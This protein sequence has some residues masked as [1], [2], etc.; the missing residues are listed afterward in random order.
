MR[1]PFLIGCLI[2]VA[3]ASAAP[4]T[5]VTG[6]WRAVLLIPD[7]GTQSISLELDAR[8]ETV[9]GSVEGLA[10]REGRLD[11]STLTLTLSAPNNQEVSLTG[12]VSGDEIVFKSTGLPPGPIQ[13]VARRNAPAVNGSV[14]DP[15]VVQQ[16][17]KQFNVPGVSI[18]VINDFKIVATYAYGVANVETRAPLTT[19]TMFQAASISKPVAAMVS[20]KAVQNGRFSLDQDVNTILKSWKLPDGPFTKERRVTPRSLMSHTSGTG[21][22]FGFPGYPPRAMLPSIPHMLD[23]VQPPSNLRAVRLERA[24]LTGFKYSGGAVMIQQ[25]AL[26]DAVGKPFEEV[27]REWVLDPIGMNNSTFE[28]PL[29]PHREKQAARAHNR[30]GARMGDPWHIYP[31][32][33]AA[34]LWTTPTDLAKFAIEVQLSLLGKSNRVLS[35]TT[36]REM[37]TPVG[38]GPYAVG[39]QI[40]KEG[41]G[42]YFMH[43]GSNWGFQCDLIAHR[44]NGYGAVIMT[45]GDGGGAL[46]PRLRRL[47]QQEYKWD[48]LAA[49]I[50]RRYGPI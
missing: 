13:F 22:G 14:S 6:R 38:V 25:L 37:V 23:G 40:G 30:M 11:G 36:V 1:R 32:Q 39:F 33:A 41:E 43:G 49:P 21:D 28:Q 44:V 17:M 2:F 10:I 48:A 24:P 18:A 19:E 15:S 29:A 4:Q 5:P 3:F 9:T 50:P 42:W 7:G 16:L 12:Q 27:A 45:N 47:I 8:G 46:I 35:Q 20:L 34:G 26:M 31:E